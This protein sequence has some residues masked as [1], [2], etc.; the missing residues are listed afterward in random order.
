[1]SPNEELKVLRQTEKIKGDLQQTHKRG[2]LAI[3]MTE[4]NANCRLPFGLA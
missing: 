3:R 2:N 4:R 1:M